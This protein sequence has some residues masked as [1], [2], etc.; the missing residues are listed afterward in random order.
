LACATVHLAC[1]IKGSTR[2]SAGPAEGNSGGSTIDEGFRLQMLPTKKYSPDEVSQIVPE[3]EQRP[4]SPARRLGSRGMND[5]PLQVHG[6]M[7][8][9]ARLEFSK[10]RLQDPVPPAPVPGA[11]GG[12]G[13]GTP[14]GVIGTP[15]P[16][17]TAG[18]SGP[19]LAV[20][21]PVL[22]IRLT[23]LASLPVPSAAAA[24]PTSVQ[25]TTD[26]ECPVLV[27][28]LPSESA[29][30]ELARQLWS[31]TKRAGNQLDQSPVT[32]ILLATEVRMGSC[33]HLMSR[34]VKILPSPLPVK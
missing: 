6:F 31:D 27:A 7:I 9:G 22:Q 24:A 5:G 19:L 12:A 32:G 1:T 3:T 10:L 26:I 8:H 34:C 21:L 30:P 20:R 11:A 33:L 28:A 29:N 17:S 14:G 18:T 2:P 25:D 16:V 4:G 15:G 23:S 13:G